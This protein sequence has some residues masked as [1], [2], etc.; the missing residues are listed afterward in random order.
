MINTTFLSLSLKHFS[1]SPLFTHPNIEMHKSLLSRQIS[2]VFFN[3]KILKIYSTTFSNSIGPIL[4]SEVVYTTR[5]SASGTCTFSNC[6]FLNISSNDDGGALYVTGGGILTITNSFFGNCKTTGIGIVFSNAG[7]VSISKVKSEKCLADYGSFLYSTGL[8]NVSVEQVLITKSSPPLQPGS[9]FSMYFSCNELSFKYT[10]SSECCVFNDGAVMGM[11]VSK[12][13]EVENCICCT[14][15]GK[16]LFYVDSQIDTNTFSRLIFLSCGS[17]DG[18][19][20][21]KAT[22]F[23]QNSIFYNTDGEF[24]KP[25]FSTIT[26]QKCFYNTEF[27]KNPKVILDNCV[28]SI[29]DLK[30]LI[31][32][33]N[34][35]FTLYFAVTVEQEVYMPFPSKTPPRTPDDSFKLNTE[36]ILIVCSI[37]LVIIIITYIFS[38]SITTKNIRAVV[39]SVFHNEVVKQRAEEEKE[40]EKLIDENEEI[41]VD[42]KPKPLYID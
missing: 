3:N 26:F 34:N 4:S 33:T 25:I 7:N 41:D 2:P 12:H 11:A 23:V 39:L 16:N 36:G 35:F 22:W 27:K 17:S 20:A 1:H 18:L 5:V 28:N 42:R 40:L 10:N 19:I 32:A 21:T 29:T 13:S 9:S 38:I 30:D 14:C 15:S 6:V 31:G 24:G 37:L 8:E